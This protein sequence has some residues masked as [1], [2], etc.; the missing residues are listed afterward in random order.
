LGGNLKEKIF[1]ESENFLEEHDKRD[2]SGFQDL[3]KYK[4]EE[5]P[6]F[7]QKKNVFFQKLTR[8]STLAVAKTSIYCHWLFLVLSV[9]LFIANSRRV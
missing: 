3:I 7:Y 8:K 1:Y 6:I 5:N 2:F 4:I 9:F